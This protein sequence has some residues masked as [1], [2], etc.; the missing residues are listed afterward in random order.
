VGEVAAD[1][2]EPR[3]GTALLLLGRG[4]SLE[5][6][7][8]VAR[9]LAGAGIHV[10]AVEHV[11]QGASPGLGRRSDA[12]HVQDFGTH[13]AAASAEA[14]RIVG[15]AFVLG[16]SMGGL[17]AMHLLVAR[18][19]RFASAVITSPM[20]GWADGLPSWAVVALSTL[21]TRAGRATD[22]AWGEKP[23]STTSCLRMRGAADDQRQGLLDFAARRPELVRGGSTWGWAL[24]ASDSLLQMRDLDMGRIST[25]V[26][27]VSCRRDRTVSRRAH[28]DLPPLLPHARVVELDAGHDPFFAGRDARTA[29]WEVIDRAAAMTRAAPRD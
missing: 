14:D 29:L 24:A 21:A 16:H 7:M 10:V 8:P 25:H 19:S 2:D 12:V 28:R 1:G 9:R 11:G 20:W 27:V 18:P 17:I 26:T 3:G 6:R 5:L 15:P 22:L 4:D 23:F 13:L